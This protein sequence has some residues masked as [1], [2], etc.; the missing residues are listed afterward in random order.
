[1]LLLIFGINTPN[2]IS[3]RGK[4]NFLCL[5]RKHMQPILQGHDLS[6]MTFLI[7]VIVKTRIRSYRLSEFSRANGKN[8]MKSVSIR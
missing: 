8:I 2:T 7:P 5:A 3:S 4:G 1:M 6:G